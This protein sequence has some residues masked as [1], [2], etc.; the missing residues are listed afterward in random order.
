MSAYSRCLCSIAACGLVLNIVGFL[1]LVRAQDQT[2]RPAFEL[3]EAYLR[4]AGLRMPSYMP[5]I[6]D[7]MAYQASLSIHQELTVEWNIIPGS[8]QSV[9]RDS[10]SEGSL[11]PNFTL[12]DRKQKVQGNA[13]ASS[14]TLRDLTLVTVAVT[15]TDE[16]RGVV[17]GPGSPIRV[18]E[19]LPR[20]GKN[21]GGQDV[22]NSKEIFQILLPDDPKISRLLFFLSHPDG[23]KYRLEQVGVL[24]LSN[25]L[26]SK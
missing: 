15:N 16:V 24:V 13:R 22:V 9:R 5:G 8:A 18:A 7:V 12:T 14:L 6:T 2:E 3:R 17:I 25:P 11:A 1:R 26:T 23:E 19:H 20:I 21:D 4:Q 10:I